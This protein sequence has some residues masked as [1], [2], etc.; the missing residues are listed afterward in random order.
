MPAGADKKSL[1]EKYMASSNEFLNESMTKFLRIIFSR[2]EREVTLASIVDPE[3][4]KSVELKNFILS[5]ARLNDYI[6][7]EIYDKDENP[8]A[9]V[10]FHADKLPVV[11]L[12]DDENYY[13]GVKFHAVP[14][15]DALIAF[16]LAIY[17]LGGPKEDFDDMLAQKILSIDK[18]IDIKIYVSLAEQ[19]FADIVTATQQLALINPNL[20]VEM[21]DVDLFPDLK[22]QYNLKTLPALIIND[23]NISPLPKALE[24]IINLLL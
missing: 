14:T 20:Q 5:I 6:L 4:L 15:G 16:S 22:K 12:I 21:I 17:N 19:N 11:S 8:D 24:E 3:N 18:P 1:V 13:M 9:E 2:L 7:T 10:F 23:E